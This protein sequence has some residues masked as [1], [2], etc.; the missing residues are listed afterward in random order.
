MT[1]RNQTLTFVANLVEQ[2]VEWL[3]LPQVSC[4]I[5]YFDKDARVGCLLY[6]LCTDVLL[7]L[8]QGRKLLQYQ[9]SHALSQR[10]TALAQLFL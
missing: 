3:L 7:G 1:Y 5:D 4:G 10:A 2:D 6:Q 8:K 9:S